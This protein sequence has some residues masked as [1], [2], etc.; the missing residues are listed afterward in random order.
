MLKRSLLIATFLFAFST[1]AQAGEPGDYQLVSDNGSTFMLNTKTG[2]LWEIRT[3]RMGKNEDIMIKYA[4]PVTVLN[5]D[6]EVIR[7]LVE[8]AELIKKLG[9]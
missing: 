6:K 2:A 8:Q 3:S 9:E 5:S 1:Q 4:A 7:F